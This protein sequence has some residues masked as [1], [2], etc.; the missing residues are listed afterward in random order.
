MGPMCVSTEGTLCY[1]L[2]LYGQDYVD[3]CHDADKGN[4]MGKDNNHSHKPH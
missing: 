4:T 3:L 1:A 2:H